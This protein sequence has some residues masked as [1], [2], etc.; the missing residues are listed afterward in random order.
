MFL[1]I[2]IR[3]TCL[4]RYIIFHILTT[5]VK[6]ES[7]QPLWNKYFCR[8]IEISVCKGTHPY[9]YFHLPFKRSYWQFF[10]SGTL[11]GGVNMESFLTFGKEILFKLLTCMYCDS[12]GS[13]KDESCII[14]YI[15][16]LNWNWR[17]HN[18]AGFFNGFELYLKLEL[19]RSSYFGS[20]SWFCHS[21]CIGISIR[22]RGRNLHIFQSP[23]VKLKLEMWEIGFT[24]FLSVHEKITFKN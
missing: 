21:P 17:A 9:S 6:H 1:W 18:R 15:S 8:R 13:F 16:Q 5:I 22:F 23:T 3:Q 7:K 10:Q 14:G 12:I 2:T 11:P 19:F 4:G 20:K 24:V